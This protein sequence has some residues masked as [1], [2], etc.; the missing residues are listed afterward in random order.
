MNPISGDDQPNPMKLL[1]IVA[2]MEVESIRAD[3]AFTKP[4]ESPALIAQQVVEEGYD[5]VVV[6]GTVSEVARGLIHASIPLGI[7]PIETYIAVVIMVRMG[8]KGGNPWLGASPPLP[9]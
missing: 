9:L 6:G 7:L 8:G 3:P 1:D 4:D 2:A 5:M